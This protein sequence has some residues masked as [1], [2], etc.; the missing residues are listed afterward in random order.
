MTTLYTATPR[1][2]PN[3]PSRDNTAASESLIDRHSHFN[4]HYRTSHDLR[5][6]GT[7]EGEI[8]C[9]GTVT[10]APEAR[11]SAT[12]KAR[13]VVIAGAASGEIVCRDQFTLKPTG[14]MRGQV[15]A[16]SL[17]VEEGAFFDGEFKMAAT[18]PEPP[19]KR[20]TKPDA[21][22]DPKLD[23]RGQPTT[24]V[25]P[26]RQVEAVKDGQAKEPNDGAIKTE[27]DKQPA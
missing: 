27:A 18:A 12:V 6:E 14:E 21:K 20:D 22:L 16:G 7:A 19:A 2:V 26:G 11:V 8:E 24:P 10:V 9:E 5:V 1:T 25:Q 15:R 4:G 23:R 13:N 17:V 3:G